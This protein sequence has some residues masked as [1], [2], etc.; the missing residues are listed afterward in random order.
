[1]YYLYLCDVNQNLSC[2]SSCYKQN[3]RMAN[4]FLGRVLVCTYLYTDLDGRN[5]HEHDILIS[6]CLQIKF[7]IPRYCNLPKG[8]NTVFTQLRKVDAVPALQMP[9]QIHGSLCISLRRQFFFTH[10]EVVATSTQ[11]FRIGTHIHFPQLREDCF[12]LNPRPDEVWRVTRP[13]EGVAQGAPPPP[14]LQK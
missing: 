1:M 4:T 3:L 11:Y 10:L 9:I 2:P 8:W 14:Y 7:K 5:L 6:W 12:N 13:D